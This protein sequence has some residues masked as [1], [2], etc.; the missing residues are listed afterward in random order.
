MDV[1]ARVDPV[2]RFPN[3]LDGGLVAIFKDVELA[4]RY[5]IAWFAIACY[6][7]L[8]LLPL[9]RTF[10]WSSKWSVAKVLFLLKRV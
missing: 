5:S 4:R 9:E 3:L 1:L 8:A 2:A 6:D 10:I 7:T